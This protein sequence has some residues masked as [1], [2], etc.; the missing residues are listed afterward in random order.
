MPRDGT[1]LYEARR[2]GGASGGGLITPRPVRLPLGIVIIVAVL[3][4]CIALLAYW[5]GFS[6]GRHEGEGG[7]R[8]AA[9]APSHTIDPIPPTTPGRPSTTPSAVADS[10]LPPAQEGDPRQ[11]GMN[12]FVIAGEVASD[13][14]VEMV[15]FCRTK[16]L[17]AVA[18]PGNNARSHVF[19]LPGFGREERGAAPVKSLEAKIRAVGAQ[20]KAQGRGNSDFHDFYPKLFKGPS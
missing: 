10:P 5:I 19:V 17:D 14:A 3:V 1:T 18:I 20:W 2:R 13:R 7:A 6:R 11:V 8:E 4:A 16:G 12:Y 9:Q 15:A